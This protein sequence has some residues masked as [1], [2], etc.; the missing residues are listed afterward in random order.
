MPTHKVI[1]RLKAPLAHQLPTICNNLR[2]H[3]NKDYVSLDFT[4]TANESRDPNTKFMLS[5][6][7]GLDGTGCSIEYFDTWSDLL[8]KYALLMGL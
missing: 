3:L 8:D 4:A 6:Q 1:R 7:P 2:L 5:F